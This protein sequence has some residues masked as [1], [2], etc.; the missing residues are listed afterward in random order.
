LLGLLLLGWRRKWGS[1]AHT[2]R[3]LCR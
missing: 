3:W 2:K 1:V